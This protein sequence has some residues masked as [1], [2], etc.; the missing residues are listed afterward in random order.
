MVFELDD[1]VK[2]VTK[3]LNQQ[4]IMIKDR[5]VKLILTTY[6]ET[7]RKELL[8]G[9][10]VEEPNICSMKLSSRKSNT[11][12]EK[13]VPTVKLNCNFI[14]D[15]KSDAVRSICMSETARRQIAPGF[16]NNDIEYLRYKYDIVDY[17]KKAD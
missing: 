9:N 3:E 5:T 2:S 14:G 17:N 13:V 12:A 6:L 15:L 1:A 10:N 16:S 8:E 4:G 11:F 7:K